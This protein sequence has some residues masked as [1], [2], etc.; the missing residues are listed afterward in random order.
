MVRDRLLGISVSKVCWNKRAVFWAK[1]CPKDFPLTQKSFPFRL[2]PASHC[3]CVPG[4]GTTCPGSLGAEHSQL[5]W[6]FCLTA[7]CLSH[8]GYYLGEERENDRG[9]IICPRSYH[10]QMAEWWHQNP[11]FNSH[12]TRYTRWSDFCKAFV[13]DCWISYNLLT[14][15][16]CG[17]H[18]SLFFPSRNSWNALLNVW[19]SLQNVW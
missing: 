18:F 11:C 1:Y 13:I 16:S 14:P 10:K 6:V 5:T 17:P 8:M 3:N 2:F 7:S 15:L 19:N 12:Y 9:Y 4:R